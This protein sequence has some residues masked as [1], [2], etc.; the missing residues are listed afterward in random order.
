VSSISV[1]LGK[2]SSGDREMFT[3]LDKSFPTLPTLELSSQDC[4]TRRLPN[5]FVA[6]RLRSLH[7]QTVDV[8]AVSSTNATNLIPLTIACILTYDCMSPEYLVEL[9]SSLLQPES[10]SIST[11]FSSVNACI[12]SVIWRRDDAYDRR[13]THCRAVR[14]HAP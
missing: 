3:A 1:G 4:V 6:P 12:S 10:L 9:L 7:L 14:S 8:W 5:G 2:W 13:H 11:R